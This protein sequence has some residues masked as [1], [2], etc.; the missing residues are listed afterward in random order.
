MCS[1]LF[2]EPGSSRYIL[3]FVALCIFHICNHLS[4][5]LCE[6]IFKLDKRQD[7]Y[8]VILKPAHLY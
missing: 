7:N 3:T 2:Y 1:F 8:K 4:Q 6:N 5:P